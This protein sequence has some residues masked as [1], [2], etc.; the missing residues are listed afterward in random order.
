MT[1][2][3]DMFKRDK[4]PLKSI[5]NRRCLTK[6]YPKNEH[7]LHPTILDVIRD[8]KITCAIDPVYGKDRNILYNDV[9]RLEDNKTYEPPNELESILLNFY[10]DPRDF[11][12]N[13]Y[14]LYSFDEVI[15]WTLENSDLPFDTI[16]RV[17]NCAWKAYGNKIEDLSDYVLDYYYNLAKNNWMTDYIKLLKNKYSF[18]VSLDEQPTVK[19]IDIKSTKS[20]VS[21]APKTSSNL[22]KNS[23]RTYVR[24]STQIPLPTQSEP[25]DKI[26][27]IQ[28]RDIIVDK[29]FDF[30]FFIKTVKKYIKTYQDVWESVE[31]HYG[32]LKNFV[33]NQLV[34]NIDRKTHNLSESDK[35]IESYDPHD[36]LITY[37]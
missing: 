4:L 23:D 9:C 21:N 31:S 29:F 18:S 8:D 27:N 11:L 7:Y 15:Y 24:D 26:S 20:S 6:C 1:T 25:E 34:I 28:I 10:F 22:E 33:Y 16:K 37:D 5:N 19:P 17:H 30:S 36:F 13:I 14:N 35:E 12:I 32:T 2:R 3:T